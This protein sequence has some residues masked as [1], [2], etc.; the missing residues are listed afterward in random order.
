M[1]VQSASGLRVDANIDWASLAHG[2]MQLKNR[3][4]RAYL[5]WPSIAEEVPCEILEDGRASES[6]RVNSS[7]LLY[8]SSSG[9]SLKL[10]TTV[11]HATLRKLCTLCSHKWQ[12]P[13]TSR[14]HLMI[15]LRPSSPAF[16]VNII[17]TLTNSITSH[18]GCLRSP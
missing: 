10:T 6:I 4:P 14:T 11:M 9:E 1:C 13:P 18:H 7:R 2:M 17:T 8:L 15:E 12:A 16:L 5:A 3:S